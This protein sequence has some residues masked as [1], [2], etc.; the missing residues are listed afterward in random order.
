MGELAREHSVD[1][2]AERGGSVT[3]SPSELRREVREELARLDVG[4]VSP[5][6]PVGDAWAIVRKSR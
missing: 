2:S 6:F 3:L 1:S 5:P 4:E